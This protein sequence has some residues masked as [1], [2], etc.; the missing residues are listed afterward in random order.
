[1][2]RETVRDELREHVHGGGATGAPG[3]G[4]PAP[5]GTGPAAPR[6]EDVNPEK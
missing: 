3:A 2:A 1:M 5:G 6:R 4:T